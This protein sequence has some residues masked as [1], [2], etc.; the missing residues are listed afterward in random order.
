[1]YTIETHAFVD[2][3]SD[4]IPY[5]DGKNNVLNTI[6]NMDDA[7][8]TFWKY[9]KN[10]K[11]AK[12]TII[13]FTSDHAHYFGKE[14]ITTLKK[15]NDKQYYP[16]FIDKVPLLIYAPNI[17]LPK[18]YDAKQSTSID[19]A[20]TI[21]HLLQIKNEKNAFVGSSLFEQDKEHL[22]IAS[23]GRN[24]YMLK[25]NNIFMP[26]NIRDKDKETFNLME[27]YIKYTHKLEKTN[28]VFPKKN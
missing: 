18:E 17:K 19:L 8:G 25:E 26:Q 21:L 3:V 28:K 23:Y 11:F 20:P 6:H 13:I 5:K 1:M 12:N 16:I 7:F 14:Y 15:H 4:G 2:I 24:L 9:F 22:G 10:S 27:K